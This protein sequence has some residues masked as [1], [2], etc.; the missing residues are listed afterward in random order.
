MNKT[1]HTFSAG[2]SPGLRLVFG[3][4]LALSLDLAVPLTAIAA[5]STVKATATYDKTLGKIIIKG[6][7]ISNY[8]PSGTWV[9]I[10]NADTNILLYTAK[11]DGNKAFSTTLQTGTN[12]CQLRLE[13]LDG[14]KTSV[15]V[16]DAAAS[17]TSAP[18]CSIGNPVK[19]TQ[20]V[21]GQS[22]TFQASGNGKGVTYSW[23]LGNGKDDL[24]GQKITQSFEQTG[25]YRVTLEG[26]TPSGQRC[27]DDVVVMVKPPANTNPN[28]KVKES[29]M[30]V[31][32]NALKA[33]DGSWVVL[34][35]EETG[36]QGGSMV[37]LPYN[38]MIPYDALNAQV[39]KK[40]KS[41]PAFGTPD[42]FS[43]YYSAASNKK[44]PV[45]AN[46]INSTSQNLFADGE[47]G[48]NYDALTSI[49][50]PTTQLPTDN[51]FVAGHDF[52]DAVIRKNEL[53]DRQHQP[54]AR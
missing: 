14:N 45:G 11:T 46:S 8:L 16:Y 22:I 21:K 53:W 25:Q 29:T 43:L 52:R 10:Y 27:A 6:T 50:N 41:K 33:A 37:N 23:N 48:A 44:D 38:P 47:I 5:G 28:P 42:Q 35:F 40:V 49:L 51:K 7:A 24:T 12:A 26:T 20:I 1:K 3:A 9:Q 36:M 19:D 4:M 30:P 17:C 34:P 18:V 32:G 2:L 39:L 15:P 54:Y 31:A 13:T